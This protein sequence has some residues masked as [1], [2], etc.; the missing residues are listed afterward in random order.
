M[1]E[2]RVIKGFEKFS[3]SN[4]GNV[5]YTDTGRIMN[6]HTNKKGYKELD[7]YSGGKKKKFRVHRLVA[8]AFIPNPNQKPVVDH[9]NTIRTDNR[10]ENLRWASV[11]ENNFNQKLGSRNTSGH[12]GITWYKPSSKWMAHI[13][14]N[15]QS[16]TIGY[17]KN[18]EDAIQAR[19]KKANELFG[20]FTNECEKI[21]ED[22]NELIQVKI[23]ELDEKQKELDELKELERELDELIKRK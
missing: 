14:F 2:F 18:K 1:E 6:Q 12:K 20:E 10:V 21:K 15:N 8:E 3:V 19:I 23:E 9:I 16:I 7:L 13:S 22:L 4:I 5:C 11:Q 17:F